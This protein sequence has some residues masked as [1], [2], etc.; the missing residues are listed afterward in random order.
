[1]CSGHSKYFVISAVLYRRLNIFG[2]HPE[3]SRY[4]VNASYFRYYNDLDVVI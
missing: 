3:C 2:S 1:M 4:V